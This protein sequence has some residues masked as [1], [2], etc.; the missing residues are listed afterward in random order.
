MIVLTAP[1]SDIGQQVLARLLE[2]NAPLRLI[3]RDP[4]K[5][6]DGVRSRVQIV[7]GSHGEA[8]VVNRAFVDADTVFWLLPPNPHAE[9]LEAAFVDFTRPAAAALKTRKVKRVVSI[10]ALGRGTPFAETAGH[11]TASLA[12]DDLLAGTGVALRALTMP[13]FM[14]NIA[15]QASA[16]KSQG[17]LSSPIDGDL[18]IPSCATRDIATVATRWLL[19]G[20]WLDQ[21]DIPVLGAAD[22]SFNEMAQIITKVF[23]IPVRFEQVSFADYK[24][25]FLRHGFSEAMAQGMR[26]MMFAKNEG[27]DLGIRRTQD[28]TTPTTFRQWC[29]NVL[30]PAMRV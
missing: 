28:N 20:Y 11:V 13:S 26:D 19:N 24:S 3:T 25:R 30:K 5:I 2:A 4:S 1:T 14:D 17:L 22:I 15:R 27:L 29:E 10:S 21:Q 6:A 16:I 9:S 12:M 8:E 18:K 23:D 7:Q